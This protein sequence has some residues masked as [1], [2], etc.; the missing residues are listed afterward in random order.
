[1]RPVLSGCGRLGGSFAFLLY[2]QSNHSLRLTPSF[3]SRNSDVAAS[4]R[5]SSSPASYGG[6]GRKATWG[7]EILV[8][9]GGA[10]KTYMPDCAAMRDRERTGG[11]WRVNVPS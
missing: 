3:L 7:N 6:T 4:L 8:R 1:M 10:E 9:T 11:H 2:R 5:P